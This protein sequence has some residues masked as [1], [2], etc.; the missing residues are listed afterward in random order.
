MIRDETRGL[1]DSEI[2]KRRSSCCSSKSRASIDWDG[3]FER[4]DCRSWACDS[5]SPVYSEIIM[6]P[7][8]KSGFENYP[9][10]TSEFFFRS[11]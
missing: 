7:M 2:M 10:I 4:D 11:R 6:F 9:V 3:G 1:V 8:I 5:T